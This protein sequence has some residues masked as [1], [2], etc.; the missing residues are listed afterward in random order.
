MLLSA[1]TQKFVHMKSSPGPQPPEQ[2]EDGYRVLVVEKAWIRH[3][4]LENGNR[5]PAGTQRG[6]SWIFFTH[7]DNSL[8][9]HRIL[10]A[11]AAVNWGLCG[12]RQ[13]VLNPF[14]GEKQK[15]LL[16][17]YMFLRS[18]ILC[19]FPPVLTWRWM[20]VGRKSSMLVQS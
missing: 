7:G 13:L 12:P 18:K 11:K 17:W 19:V 1:W 6:H 5:T 15:F 9:V 8:S 16:I 14:S 10:E 4:N 3:R 2:N 20:R